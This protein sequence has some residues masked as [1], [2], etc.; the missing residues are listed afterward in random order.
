MKSILFAALVLASVSAVAQDAVLQGC[1]S[2]VKFIDSGDT[3]DSIGTTACFSYIRGV[4]ETHGLFVAAQPGRQLIYCEP[5][6]VTNNQR[7]KV[8]HKWLNNHP[9]QCKHPAIP[10]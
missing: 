1:T 8:V 3:Q 9:E 2:A 7:V 4:V 6:G 10:S 5:P